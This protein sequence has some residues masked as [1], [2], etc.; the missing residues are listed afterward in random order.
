MTGSAGRLP[1]AGVVLTGGAS[2]RMGRDKALLEVGGVALAARVAGVLMEAGCRPVWCQGGDAAALTAAGLAVRP[3]TRPSEGPVMAIADALAAL[4]PGWSGIVA[5]ACD[6]PDLT[7][8]AVADLLAAAAPGGP[9]T[10][11][12]D[13]QPQLVSWWPAASA[14]PLAAHLAGGRRAYRAAL[15]ALGAVLVDVPAAV[16][17]NVNTPGDL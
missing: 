5:A 15:E 13:A 12:V 10:L 6:L 9:A 11:A 7:A 17:R 8:A 16:V 14:A 1:V 4:E 3:D 2:R